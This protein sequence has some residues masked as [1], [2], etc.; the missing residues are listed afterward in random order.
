MTIQYGL[1]R[2][3][4]IYSESVRFIFICRCRNKII[5]PLIS[6][7]F[8]IRI[9]AIT[10]AEGKTI[11]NDICSKENISITNEILEYIINE[12]IIYNDMINIRNIIN[13]LN[14]TY[15]CEDDN[16]KYIKYDN[17]FNKEL[18]N[19]ILSLQTDNI[20]YSLYNK[21]KTYIDKHMLLNTN[22]ANII[23]YILYKL[24]QCDYSNDI[25]FKLIELMSDSKIYLCNKT[26]L[27]LENILFTVIKIIRE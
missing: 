16:Y 26:T 22:Y 11:L 5:N 15:I 18:D 1:R 8:C 4:E 6:R 9:R 21:I 19:L 13:H 3:I 23:K 20:T 7:L 27:F 24:L 10:L 25:K 14:M 12:N 17:E 2:I